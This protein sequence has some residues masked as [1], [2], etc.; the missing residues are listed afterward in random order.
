MHFRF[1]LIPK[2]PGA[3]WRDL[4]NKKVLLSNGQYAERLWYYYRFVSG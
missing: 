4:P 2:K 3:D 1:Q